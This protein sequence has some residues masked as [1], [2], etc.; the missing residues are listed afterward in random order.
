MKILW[1]S[2]LV[3]YPPNAGVAQR[4][5]GLLAQLARRHDVFLMAFH[6]KALMRAMSN[7][8][9]L[10]LAR[11]IQHLKSVCASVSVFEIPTERSLFSKY[12]LAATTPFRRHAFTLNWLRSRE[13]DDALVSL[14]REK[15]DIAHFD[16]ISLGI[17]QRHLEGTVC[18]MNHH[19][20]ESHLLFRRAEKTHS[21][22]RKLYFRQEARRLQEFERQTASDYQ[23]HVTC[24]DL[25]RQRLAAS[26]PDAKSCVIPNGVDIAFFDRQVPAEP[27]PVFSFAGTLGWGPNREAAETIVSSLWP[28]ISSKWPEARM[29]LI[30]SNP[31]QSALNL[32][33]RDKRFVVTGF[34]DDVRPHLAQSS[35]FLCPIR[36]GGGTKLKI[37]NAMAMGKVVIA[38]PIA[39]EGIS[40]SSG[41]HAFLASTPTEYVD[42]AARLIDNRDTFLKVAGAARALIE[43][44]YSYEVI[45]KELD[46]RYQQAKDDFAKSKT[47]AD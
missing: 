41:Q 35:F 1:L 22:P 5:Y 47:G 27:Q 30:G 10:C 42:T 20:V 7:D 3:P 38:D 29:V 11:S 40:V 36:D 2:H 26:A 33:R 9:E 46:I 4:S 21:I 32:A 19:N 15:F 39:V 43:Q 34:V 12:S 25:D 17:F 23:L 6:Q 37:L 44:Q 18:T 45:G 28:A 16:T 13:F 14:S 8:A 31:P 24:S